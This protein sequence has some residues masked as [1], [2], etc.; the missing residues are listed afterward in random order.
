MGKILNIVAEGWSI[1]L[2]PMLMPMYGILLFFHATPFNQIPI[3]KTYTIIGIIGTIVLTW[4]IPV[5]LLL[6]MR[7]MGEITSIHMHNNNERTKPYIYTLVCYGFWAYFMFSIMKFPTIIFIIIVGAIA[8]LTI[9]TII[10]H[11]W[12]ISAHLTGIGGLLGGVCSF[13]MYYATLSLPLIEIIL[14]LSLFLIYARIYTKAH[15]PMQ[16]VCGFLLGLFCTF[17]PTLF[18]VYA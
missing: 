3:S 10:N 1:V 13:S 14:A 18:I 2:H 4:F 11:W 16:V 6:C 17:V 7:R 8:A 5:I 12:K 9:V 15:T